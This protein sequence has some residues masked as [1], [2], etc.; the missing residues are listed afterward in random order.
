VALRP[1]VA[2]RIVQ[3]VPSRLRV[4]SLRI[5]RIVGRAASGIASLSSVKTR[6]ATLEKDKVLVVVATDP[7]AAWCQHPAGLRRVDNLLVYPVDPP[8]AAK[9]ALEDLD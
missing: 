3:R 1:A 9:A 7:V 6:S 5:E 8:P 2:P 4:L